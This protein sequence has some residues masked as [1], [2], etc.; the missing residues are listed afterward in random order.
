MIL[1]GQRL[2]LPFFLRCSFEFGLFLPL[3]GRI[4]AAAAELGLAK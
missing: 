4:F 2:A 3:C 1:K